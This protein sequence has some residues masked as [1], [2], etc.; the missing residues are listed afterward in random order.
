MV[1]QAV[2][3]KAA[4]IKH[5]RVRVGYTETAPPAKR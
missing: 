3:V 1:R 2:A 4:D 5:N